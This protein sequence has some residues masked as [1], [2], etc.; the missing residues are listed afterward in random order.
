MSLI[1]L[2]VACLVET[3]PGNYGYIRG[4]VISVHEYTI[5]QTLIVDTGSKFAATNTL[6]CEFRGIKVSKLA[7]TP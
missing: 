3:S 2:M 1:G 7:K 4:Q 5:G 6:D